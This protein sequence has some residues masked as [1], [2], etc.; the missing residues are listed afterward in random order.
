MLI[1][2]PEIVDP[3]SVP[4]LRWGVIG[5]GGIAEVFVDACQKHTK[6]HFQAVASRTSGRAD[7]FAAKF[8]IPQ[9]HTDYESLVSTENIDAVYIASWQYEHFEHAMLA[10]NAGKHVLVEK[11]ITVLPEHAR[12]IFKLAASKGLMA[13]EAMWTRYLP[14]S[15][16]IRKLLAEGSLGAPQLFAA[17]FS[18]DNRHISRLW[19]KGGGSIIY[20]M[21]IYPI[22]MSQQFLGNPTKL[23]AIGTLHESGLDAES[24][25]VFEYES[26]ARA[27]VTASGIAT[28]PT[29]ASCSFENGVV[30]VEEPFFVPSGIRVRDK[31]LYFEE[32]AW[33]DETGIRG[34][35]GL[36][37]QAT[38]FA[39]YVS[40]GR[41]ESEVHPASEVVAGIEIAA[42]ICRQIGAEPI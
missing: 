36:N 31:E 30:V 2:E 11:P 5:P 42:E 24:H 9:T 13:M 14:Q 41:V 20:D 22:A 7:E 18:V 29:T 28:L 33:F 23:T 38:W 1:P 12:E 10:L 4:A 35:E 3:A 17:N 6:Q 39:K 34:H 15:T 27:Q 40:E 8:S 25:S 16:V 32:Q 21:G 37:Y 19:Q 26:G